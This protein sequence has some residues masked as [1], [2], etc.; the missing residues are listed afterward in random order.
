MT[1]QAHLRPLEDYGIVEVTGDD[2]ATFLQR[3]LTVDVL[4]VSQDRA[5]FGAYLNPKGRVIA[6]FILAKNENVF[7]FVLNKELA[8]HLADRLKIFVFRD[9]I[10][11][12]AKTDFI[13]AGGHLDRDIPDS[14]LPQE[15][16]QTQA[17]D[18]MIIIR[19]P[20]PHARR[21]GV[22]SNM[23]KLTEIKGFV[24]G[25]DAR[26]WHQHEINAGIPW[27][28]PDTSEMFVAQGVNL[29][30]ID[31]VS[32]TKG[33]Y[34]GQEIVARLHY[35]G[36]TN[37]RMCFAIGTKGLIAKPGDE[38]T[39]PELAGHQ[40]GTVVNCIDDDNFCILLISIPLKFVNQETLLLSG[41]QP[42][43]LN[44]DRMPYGVPELIQS[45]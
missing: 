1:N 12:T 20:D 6:N 25:M 41:E 8:Q 36:G 33:C 31:A 16:L 22:I 10:N 7:F 39:C 3:Q 18:G 37:R 24:Q 15:S 4:D 13:F 14:D 43:S 5:Q 40:I 32:W 2:A 35:R 28:T 30:L 42:I 21:Y 9:K 17:K 38:V 19:M 26:R 34:P 27:I 29:D 23:D 44:A 11:I 45:D